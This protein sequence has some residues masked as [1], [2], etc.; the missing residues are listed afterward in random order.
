MYRLKATITALL[1]AIQLHRACLK[2]LTHFWSTMPM[3]IF[4]QRWENCFVASF[5]NLDLVTK[6]LKN[7]ADVNA[8][9]ADEWHGNW[10]QYLQSN[11]R[12]SKKKEK[13]N[14]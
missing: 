5:G 4:G 8:H 10:W 6:L 1:M 13:K 12:L 3:S 2:Q 14:A 9:I 7:N 11:L